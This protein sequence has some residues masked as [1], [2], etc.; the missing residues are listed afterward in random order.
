MIARAGAAIAAAALL[1]GCAGGAGSRQQQPGPITA[2]PDC[3]VE[4]VYGTVEGY[5]DDGLYTFKGIQYAKC[6]RFMPPQAPDHFDGV[7]MCKIYGP[8]ATQGQTFD[9][10]P[11]QSDYDFGNNFVMEPMSD[12]ECLVLNVWT[13]AINDGKKRPVFVWI[14]GGGY[15]TGSGHDLPCYDQGSLARKGD[16]VTV[17]INHRLNI[18]GFANLTGLG[19]KYAESVNLGVQDMIK[20]LEWIHDN[21]AQFGGD[22]DCV[23]IAGQ[24]GGGG[25][26][27]ILMGAPAAHGLFHRAII[28]SGMN[29]VRLEDAEQSRAFGPAFAQA[30]GVAPGPDADFSAFSYQELLDASRAVSRSGI[31]ASQG[32]MK[33][34]NILPYDSFGEGGLQL[35]EDVPL[36]IGTNFNEFTFDIGAEPT[37]E[38]I[39]AQLAQRVGEDNVADFVAQFKAAFPDEPAK[40][41]LYMDT[42]FRGGM[43]DMAAAKAALGRKNVYLY[44]FMWKPSA[45]VLGASHG[46]ELPM[47]SNNVHLQREMTGATPDAYK[48]ADIMSNYW[49]AFI[50]TGNPNVR[51]QVAWEPYEPATGACLM[52][53]T[54]CK[55]QYNHDRPLI[56]MLAAHAPAFGAPR[57]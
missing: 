25:K 40:A 12:T 22:P 2:G 1:A 31:R 23:T 10:K 52:I 11:K 35:S 54:K 9:W 30:L 21:I 56:D 4:T 27:G 41:M 6:E 46:M 32:P 39:M 26:I 33:D 45:N 51:G 14:H 57:R 48:V 43:L 38:E 50:K 29:V 5:L 24:S 47:M 49:L 16:I 15:S 19:G 42:R 18:L 28:Q 44:Q 17:S 8:K 37:E 3:Q 20:A 7:R 53:D 36:I 13:K 34:G 55:V